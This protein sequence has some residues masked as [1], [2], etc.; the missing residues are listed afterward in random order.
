MT[1]KSSTPSKWNASIFREYDI[2]GIA[3]KDLNPDFA[4]HLGQVYAQYISGRKPLKGRKNLTVAVGKDCRLSSDDLTDGLV[5]GL[6]AGGL[7]VIQLG[8]CPTPLTYFSVFELDLDGG[9]MVTGSHNPAD[10]NGFKIS[11]GRDTIHGHQIQELRE[12]MDKPAVKGARA[13]EISSFDPIP[14]YIDY[15]VKHAKKLTKKKI[16]LDA[17]NGT[18]STVAP[19]LFRR[20]GAEVIELYCELDGRFPNH[21]P[22]P[23]VPANL[24]DMIAVMKKEGADFGIAF[25]G[26][27]DRIGLADEKGTVIYGDEMMVLFSRNVL[28]ENP[29]ATVISEVKSSYRLYDDIAKKGGVPIMWK[30]GHSLIKAK[31]KETKALLAGEMSGHIFFAD[32]YFGYDDAIYAGAR[33]YEIACGTPEPFSSLLADLE[34]TV[35]T[36]EIR[37]DCE[38]DKKFKLV[39]GTK[40][41]LR[42]MGA[43]KVND[44]DG[45]R[46]DFGD[47][48]GLVRASNT[49]PVIVL[50]F[51]AKT[52]VRMDEIRKTVEDAL[53]MTAKEVGH[54]PL[55][56]HGT[57]H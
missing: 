43:G 35:N 21:H 24:A 25:D 51:E 32:R 56:T 17:G 22:D 14:P 29:G 33:V 39:E 53:A 18:A 5:R 19:E 36:P 40:N 4:E 13:G 54:A 1:Q 10:Y 15:V 55:D 20:L 27:S 34:K 26:D 28:K 38:E 41:R 6:V 9:I 48:W 52:K 42:A 3:G 12:L 37:V 7:D 47:G 31:M 44:I 57:S 45:I 30:T 16:V 50:R 2:R 11:V 23:T 49:Q 8:V 46:V